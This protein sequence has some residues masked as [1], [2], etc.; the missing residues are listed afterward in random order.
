MFK[1][2]KSEVL[3][4]DE[5]SEGEGDAPWHRE[6]ADKVSRARGRSGSNQTKTSLASVALSITRERRFNLPI[7]GVIYFFII[8]FFKCMY[9]KCLIAI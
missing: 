3:V 5:T 1:R 8:I 4:D 9:G 7:I 2:S 6:R